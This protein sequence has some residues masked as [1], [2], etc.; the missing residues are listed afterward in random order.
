MKLDEPLRTSKMQL[1]SRLVYPPMA[2]GSSSNGCPSQ[3]TL[4]HYLQVAANPHV[5]LLITEHS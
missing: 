5:G 1:K 3:R 2:T 4:E